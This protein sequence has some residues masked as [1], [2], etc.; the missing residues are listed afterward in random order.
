LLRA[1]IDRVLGLFG[2]DFNDS[3]DEMVSE[4]VQQSQTKG[5]V[6]EPQ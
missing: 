4:E 6:S 3:E 1:D 2:A 5:G